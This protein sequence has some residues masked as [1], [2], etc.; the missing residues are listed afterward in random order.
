[1][2]YEVNKYTTYLFVLFLAFKSFPLNSCHVQNICVRK[3]IR[4]TWKFF[5]W[6]E[7][8][9]IR[10]HYIALQ[11]LLLI[12]PLVFDR[13]S[14]SQPQ[15]ILVRFRLDNHIFWC[16]FLWGTILQSNSHSHCSLGKLQWKTGDFYMYSVICTN[17]KIFCLNNN[18]NKRRTWIV[19]NFV[20]QL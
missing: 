6:R 11:F 12:S 2:V 1:M 7:N 14:H 5:L 15:S 13:G 3:R 18:Q 20:C 16:M 8:Q 19:L 4:K 9:P 10:S 17:L